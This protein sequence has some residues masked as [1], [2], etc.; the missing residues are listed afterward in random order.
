MA[1]IV[2]AV[3]GLLDILPFEGVAAAAK[4][5]ELRQQDE[6]RINCVVDSEDL[7]TAFFADTSYEIHGLKYRLT[8]LMWCLFSWGWIEDGEA[9]A[10]MVVLEAP[11]EI[12]WLTKLSYHR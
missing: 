4:G 6:G 10:A 1:E 11:A 7:P 12:R 8:L 3:L 2:L 5:E 9:G